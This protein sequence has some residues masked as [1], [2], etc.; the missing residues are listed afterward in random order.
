MSIEQLQNLLD[1]AVSY[2]DELDIELKYLEGEQA[3]DTA[4]EIQQLTNKIREIESQIANQDNQIFNTKFWNLIN[5][6]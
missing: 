1:S 4:M 2:R 5:K 3:R 6:S